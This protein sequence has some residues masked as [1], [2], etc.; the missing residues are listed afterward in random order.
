VWPHLGLAYVGTVAKR[1]GYDVVLH[2]EWIQ[3][4][5][6]MEKLVGEG[7]VVGLS[8]VTTGIERGVELA[9]SAKALGA[10]YVIAGND[11]AAFRD[12][13]LLEL[14]DAP[15][16]AVFTSNS[17]VA[18]ASFLRSI[19]MTSIEGLRIP[20]VAIR[21][22]AYRLSNEPNSLAWQKENYRADDFFMVPDLSV[23]DR[24]YWELVWSAYRSQFGHKHRDAG[25]LRNAVALLSHGCGRAAVGDACRYCSIGGVANFAM[26]D[27]N[28]IER[29]LDAYA[30][31]GISV[32]FNAA[33]SAIEQLELAD[34]LAQRGPVPSLVLYGR[35]QVITSR[36]LAR[37]QDAAS[38]RLLINCGMDSGDD[39]LL[40]K[41]VQKAA[42]TR[43]SRLEENRRAL[44]AIRDAGE[45]FHLHYSV[46]FG[47][48]GE[49]TDSCERTLALI[50]ESIDVLRH[51]QQLDIVESDRWWLNFGAACAE[52]FRSYDY[53]DTLAQSVGRSISR[54]DWKR[55][56]ALHA[57]ALVVPASCQEAWYR[58]FTDISLDI[59]DEYIEK[60]KRR[61]SN[62]PGAIIGRNFAFRKPSP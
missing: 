44:R 32:F 28:Y 33:D 9:R 48:P 5:T 2:D 42:N 61:M 18:V 7:D 46:I 12:Q 37:W 54:A 4:Q 11:S 47:S 45:K 60:V 1:C 34:A 26:P 55:E 43:G 14:P 17:V 49:T 24:P 6:S 56:F 52:I 20:H 25:S 13:Q 21:G 36:T 8:L 16:D 53:A 31:F 29:T 27:K 38:E 30:L 3:G 23:F 40:Q 41:A 22:H 35:A 10:S 15:I 51:K 57:D 58:H 59:A 62:V 50:D 39:S 19:A